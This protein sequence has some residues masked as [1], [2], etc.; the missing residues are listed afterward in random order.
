MLAEIQ[1][2]SQAQDFAPPESPFSEL[3]VTPLGMPRPSPPTKQPG[4]AIALGTYKGGMVADAFYEVKRYPVPL[5]REMLQNYRTILEEI[6]ADP[7]K[8]IS[9]FSFV[10]GSA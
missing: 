7:E 1:S 9:G 10:A 2:P 8:E 3:A 4:I 5:M 6:V